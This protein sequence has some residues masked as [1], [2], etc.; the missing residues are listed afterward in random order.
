MRRL[1]KHESVLRDLSAS[2]STLRFE[3]IS[4]PSSGNDQQLGRT[5]PAETKALTPAC[6]VASKIVSMH[7]QY[8]GEGEER[9][10]RTGHS[11]RIV[12]NHGAE[13]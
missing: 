1:T 13:P 7:H 8:G 10:E 2:E 6:F 11:L 4:R 12:D 3:R 5:Q 9:E